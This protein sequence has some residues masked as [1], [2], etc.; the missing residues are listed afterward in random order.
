MQR[1]PARVSDGRLLPDF[2]ALPERLGAS[3]AVLPGIYPV[4]LLLSRAPA[5]R[6][7]TERLAPLATVGKAS[8]LVVSGCRPADGTSS[9]AA[10][11][12]I[13]LS[14]RLMLKTLLVDANGRHPS[15]HQ[16]FAPPGCLSQIVLDGA[17][18][19]R[20]TGWP[21]LNLATFCLFDGDTERGRAL[22]QFE[23]LLG[24]HDTA[25]IDLGVVR[26]DARMLLLA[27]PKDP[28]LLVVRYGATERRE[29]AN[30]AAALK[31]ANRS[32]AGVILN[33]AQNRM[34]QLAD[35]RKRK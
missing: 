10:A 19:I 2:S 17:L 8:R 32:V 5:M 18:Q 35:Q 15:L 11:F 22:A 33:A 20:S 29:L 27:R 12:A 24:S 14:Q 25:V 9:I 4:P 21:R 13:D 34:S 30:S 26:L 7:L 28:I 6:S 23:R 31:A 1:L 3:P 16:V